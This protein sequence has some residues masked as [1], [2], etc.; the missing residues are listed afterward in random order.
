MVGVAGN[1]GV[2]GTI[3]VIDDSV[4]DGRVI[5]DGTDD[6]LWYIDVLADNALWCINVGVTFC[7]LYEE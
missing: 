5:G 4:V 6:T 2:V 7:C 3:G 1:V